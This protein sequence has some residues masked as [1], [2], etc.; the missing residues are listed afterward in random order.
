[1]FGKRVLLRVAEDKAPLK[2]F[3]KNKKLSYLKKRLKD[4]GGKWLGFKI[5]KQGEVVVRIRRNAHKCFYLIVDEYLG[6]NKIIV[7]DAL[8]K[9]KGVAIRFNKDSFSLEPHLNKKGQGF[10]Q[11]A[12][13]KLKDKQRI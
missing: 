7:R 4:N 12:L 8:G 2:S 10:I 3:M 1:M 6:E 13:N 9:E 5:G 11:K